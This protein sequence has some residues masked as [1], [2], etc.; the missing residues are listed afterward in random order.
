MA[1]MGSNLAR[2]LAR[3]GHVVAV[4]NRTTARTEA[5]LTAHGHEGTFLAAPDLETFVASLV[6]PRRIIVMVQAGPGTDAVLDALV[7][8]LE[9]GDIVVDGGNAHY[10]DTR[11]REQRLR[12]EGLHFVGAGISGGEVGALEGPSIMPGGSPESYAALGPILESIAA[13]VDGEPCCA[14]MGPDGA[15]HFV[16]MVHNGI[17]YADM[18]F[19][20][21][22]YDLLRA[23]G[24]EPQAMSET[25]RRWNEGDLDSYLVEVTAEVLAQQDARTGD[26]LVDSIVDAAGQKGTG[27]WTVQAALELGVPVNAIAESVFARSASSHPELRAAARGALAGPARTID[28]EGGLDRFVEDV[29]QSLWSAKVVAYAQGLHL[30]RVASDTYGWDVDIESVARIWRAGCIIRARLLE[31]IR[32][33]YAA[34]HLVTLLE[35]PGIRDGLAGTQESWRRVVGVAA[36]AG[37]PVP[38]FAASLAYYDTLRADRLPAALVQGQRD[39]FGAHTYGRVDE[40]GSFHTDWSGDRSEARVG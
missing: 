14:H 30:I 3:R 5:V 26:A 18:Q 17:E 29:R 15:G 24:V 20:A 9:E 13:D 22:A 25:F 39:Y 12:G 7:P 33:E 28:L 23:A 2:N 32:S 21:E 37:V 10:Q 4:F 6:R 16:K 38:G 35:A 31:R 40:E 27:S 36:R 11:R 8:L 19:I 1:V 34:H